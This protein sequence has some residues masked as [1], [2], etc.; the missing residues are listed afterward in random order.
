[1]RNPNA[2]T[3]THQKDK[4]L[5]PVFVVIFTRPLV[6]EKSQDNGSRGSRESRRSRRSGSGNTI[7]HGWG[8]SLQ[9]LCIRGPG[10]LGERLEVECFTFHPSAEPGF[11]LSRG[12]GFTFHGP[13][14][15]HGF[16]RAFEAPGF[17]ISRRKV[18]H[19]TGFGEECAASP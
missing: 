6:P 1:M 16:S 18:S 3:H 19:F 17:H 5:S 2:H 15:R 11:R 10:P 8:R 14:G 7:S 12:L 9:A 4:P 13:S